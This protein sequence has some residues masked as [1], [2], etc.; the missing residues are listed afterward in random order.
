L[1]VGRS[2]KP[3][4]HLFQ[5]QPVFGVMLSGSLKTIYISILACL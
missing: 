1:E 4:P 2:R 3:H 5:R